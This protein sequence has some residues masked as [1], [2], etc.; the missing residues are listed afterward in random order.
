MHIVEAVAQYLRTMR[1]IPDKDVSNIQFSDL[2]GS[3]STEYVN[4]K[5]YQGG[6][7]DQSEEG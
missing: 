4:L 2:F 3:S 7:T 5:V 6:K 1:M